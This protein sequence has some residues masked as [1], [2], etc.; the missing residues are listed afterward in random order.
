LRGRGRTAR[1]AG[2]HAGAPQ[3]GALGA[4]PVDIGRAPARG[5]RDELAPAVRRARRAR[6]RGLI[7]RER[8]L[9]VGIDFEV[10]L[11]ADPADLHGLVDHAHARADLHAL[12][13]LRN[14]VG[15]EADAAA[16]RGAPGAS[17][18][19]R[20]VDQVARPAQ[21]QWVLAERL[22][23][24]GLDRARQLRI[25]AARRLARHP[26]RLL[27]LGGADGLAERRRITFL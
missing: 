13:E 12:V 20:P 17:R 24:A 25:V 6:I 19:V 5:T 8:L 4:R 14:V 18:V 7:E 15:V 27:A 3:R 11:A 16:A 9:G 1:D 22:V 2:G 10:E 23:G 26:G 21:V